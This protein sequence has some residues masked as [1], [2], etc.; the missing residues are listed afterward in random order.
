MT[1]RQL[2]LCAAGLALLVA[3][4]LSTLM[5]PSAAAL[6]PAGAS[7]KTSIQAASTKKRQ[8]PVILSGEV[9]AINSQAIFVP[10]SNSS[11]VVLRNFVAEGSIVKTGDLLLRIETQGNTN[12]EQLRIEAAQAQAIAEREVADLEVKAI[13]AEK[14]LVGTQAALAKAR[15]D[16]ALPKSQI[17]ALD[18]DRYQGERERAE[19]DLVVR[20]KAH[21]NANEAIARRRNDSELEQKKLHINLIFTQAQLA[22]SEVR[23]RQDGVVVHGYSAWRGERYEEG[24]SAFPGNRV[25]QVMGAGQMLVRAWAL[26]ADRLFL[27]EGQQLSLH[28]DALPGKSLQAQISQIASAPEARA[29]WGNGRYF[30]IE[31]ALPSGHGLA[32]VPGMSVQIEA[33]SKV[34][35]APAARSTSEAEL[36]I[37]GEIASRLATPIAPP[38][39]QNVWQYT[40]AHIAAER[41]LVQAGQPIASFEATEVSS[42]LDTQRSA[43]NEKQRALEKLK[44]DQAEADKGGDLAVSEA[45]SNAEKAARKASL[46]K[47]LIRRVDYDKLV[48]E[49]SLNA[50]L[51]ELATR[52]RQAQGRA[53]KA[54]L[55]GLQSELAQLHSSIDLLSKGQKALSVAA[56]RSGMLLYR[57]SFNGDKFAIGSRVWMGLSVATLA[58]PEQLFVIAKVP[59]AQAVAAYVGQPARIN[60]PGANQALAAHVSALGLI[61]HSKSASQ[62]VIVRDLEIT[63]DSPPKDLKP[64]A[65]VQAALLLKTGDKPGNMLPKQ[66]AAINNSN[67]GTP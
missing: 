67:R 4:S 17:S 37:E 16:A 32:L 30:R 61:Y 21:E 66:T 15:V 27:S 8:R 11:P 1:R 53:R 43:L 36:S 29:S 41:A 33:M 6:R 9:D 52:Q 23:A 5:R 44:L 46:P 19:R 48:I 12:L 40:L 45:H 26:E 34:G 10:P 18:Y 56:P 13:E 22:Q 58:D 24:S 31:I 65:A 54:E 55:A 64:G 25:G 38:T 51:A 60:L 50:Q 63:F 7:T 14:L 20:Q 39:I 3:L 35:A 62:P 2:I 47:D 59:E 42:Q 57:T 28:F 49:R